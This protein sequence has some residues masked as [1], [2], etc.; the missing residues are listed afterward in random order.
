MPKGPRKFQFS[1][2]KDGLTRYAGLML[3]HQFCKSIGLRYFLQHYVRWPDYY[4]RSYHPADIF[5]THLFSIVVGIGRIENTQSLYHNG[6][7]PP[8][9]GFSDFPHR[10]TLR[11]FLRR[12]NATHL[13]SLQSAHDTLRSKLFH[14]MQLGYTAII[15]T[16]TTPLTVFG[17]QQETASGYNPKYHGKHSYSPLLSSEGTTGLSLGILLRPGNFH[18]SAG[19]LDFLKIILQKLPSS[20]AATRVRLRLDGGFYDKDIIHFLDKE[21]YRYIISAKMTRPLRKKIVGARYH[22]FSQQWEASRFTYTPFHWNQRHQFVAIR[23]PINQENKE[24]QQQLFTFKKYIYPQALVSNLSL[25]PE[26]I[27][28]S[29]RGRANQE[30]LIRE[31]KDSYYMAKIPS[32]AFYANAAYMEIITWAYDLVLA[33]QYL[34]L[35]SQ[36]QHWNIA[37]LRRELWWLPAEWVKRENRN[38]LLLPQ[39]YHY[40]KLFTKI[41]RTISKLK[42]IF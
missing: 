30:L 20:I 42:P 11:E 41:Q 4:Y 5:L 22:Q 14:R 32:R 3:F 1:F 37:T 26:A 13:K 17:H 19:A 25:T 8:L 7:I 39:K 24:R 2:T 23:C 12:F 31:L 34:C 27:Y 16:D 40:Q 35:P 28:R 10:D 9:L 36:Y 6:L 38:M 18:S 15:D 33:F 29:Y 21:E